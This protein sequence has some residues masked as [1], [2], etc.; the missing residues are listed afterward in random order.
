MKNKT[1]SFLEDLQNLT[2]QAENIQAENVKSYIKK[3]HLETIKNRLISEAMKGKYSYT[4]Y[5]PAPPE[6]KDYK[7]NII[8]TAIKNAFIEELN[9]PENAVEFKE[10]CWSF[11]N[12]D[13]YFFS[14]HWN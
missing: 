1:T 4:F 8:S 2:K 11:D 10:I 13:K 9:L 3:K 14:I 5:I 6:W 12:T 7:K